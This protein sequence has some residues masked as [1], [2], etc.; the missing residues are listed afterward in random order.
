MLQAQRDEKLKTI[1]EREA[2]MIKATQEAMNAEAEENL[3]AELART[4]AASVLAEEEAIRAEAMKKQ[5]AED[6]SLASEQAEK[7]KTESA[8]AVSEACSNDVLRDRK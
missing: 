1:Q 6:H 2:L 4:D 7:D 8:K 3:R 5:Q